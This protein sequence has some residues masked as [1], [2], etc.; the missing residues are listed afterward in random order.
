MDESS[1]RILALEA[2]VKELQ[3]QLKK[4]ER[5]RSRLNNEYELMRGLREREA[6]LR[7]IAE[8]ERRQQGMYARL[9][10]T[11]MTD[12]FMLFDTSLNLLMCSDTLTKNN[13]FGIER[14]ASVGLNIKEVLID[15]YGQAISETDVDEI[16]YSARDAITDRMAHVLSKRFVFSSGREVVAEL[17]ISP[18]FRT[19]TE[20]AGVAVTLIDTTE[21]ANARIRAENADTAKSNFLAN[22]SHEIRTPMNAINGMAEFIVRDTVDELARQNAMQIKSSA[23]ALL[24]IINDILDFSKIEAG[25][26]EIIDVPYQTT[27]IINDVATIIEVKMK[28]KAL[29]LELDIAE[30][31]PCEMLGDEIRIK[32]VLLNL[33]NNAVKFTKKGSI[34]LKMWQ[35]QLGED[36]VRIFADIKDTGQGIRQED[37]GNL[38]NSF[39]QVDTQ[40]NRS[41]EG[42]GLGLAICQ[43]LT[44]AMNGGISV[45]SEYGKGS[46]FSI[47]FVNKITNPAPIGKIERGALKTRIEL[48]TYDFIAPKARVLVVDDNQVNLMVATGMLKPYHVQVETAS[49]GPDAI[50]KCKTT[51]YDIVF[52]DHMMP[53]MDGMEAMR[54]IRELPNGKERVIIALTANA[55]SGVQQMYEEAG[56]HGFLAKPIED[57]KL[58]QMLRDFLPKEFQEEISPVKASKSDEPD[59]ELLRIV[60]KEGVQKL[61]LLPT[62]VE[63]RDLPRYAIEVH[64]IK[65]VMASVHQNLISEQ[66]K[67]H[68]M[69]SKNG[70]MDYVLTNFDALFEDY[71]NYI[72]SLAGRFAES[73]I[74]GEIAETPYTEEE[75][76][77]VMNQIR[78]AYEEFDLD[79]AKELAKDACSHVEDREKRSLFSSLVEAADA[80]DYD[81]LEENLWQLGVQL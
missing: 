37:I 3:K 22:M 53:V 77:E 2:E 72:E 80:Y 34:T 64:A 5:K 24:T 44:E 38:F 49:S 57:E 54:K 21:L 75:L 9:I 15:L 79:K 16:V 33:L 60:Y 68:E 71:R 81:K 11:N 12:L 26:M 27:S 18:A 17:R 48:F 58:D 7:D 29:K 30:D 78:T 47:H 35:E 46:T 59:D 43:R 10:M 20:L 65:S 42:T 6:T 70:N 61:N 62:L 76:S 52:M 25:K 23:S 31:I 56:F 36:E 28:E 45:E 55:I 39:S 1:E 13:L 41:I 50:E 4:S 73:E 66:A 63:N 69:Q 51:D 8:N 67:E 14:K 19:E 40:K 32:Q 74:V